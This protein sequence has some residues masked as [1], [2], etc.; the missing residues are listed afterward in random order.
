LFI[1]EYLKSKINDEL[2]DVYRDII[3]RIIYEK[4]NQQKEKKSLS[5]RLK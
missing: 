4:S 3:S 1:E 5:K 2:V